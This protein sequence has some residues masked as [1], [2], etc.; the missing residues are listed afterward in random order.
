L[1]LVAEASGYSPRHY[2][3]VPNA[4]ELVIAL[5]PER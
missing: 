4:N 1:D 2:E 3:A 5:T